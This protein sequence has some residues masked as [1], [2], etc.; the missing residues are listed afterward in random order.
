MVDDSPVEFFFREGTA[1]F[2]MWNRRSMQSRNDIATPAPLI[3]VKIALP[4]H[5]PMCSV[6][7]QMLLSKANMSS[8]FS[9]SIVF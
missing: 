5:Q 1:R 6:M 7:K 3:S 2:L 8:L 9:R 4:L